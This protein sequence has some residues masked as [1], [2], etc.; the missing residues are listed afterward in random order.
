MRSRRTFLSVIA[1]MLGLVAASCGG[2]TAGPATDDGVAGALLVPAEYATIQL[3]VDAAQPGDLVLIDPGVYRES[4]VVETNRIV[5]RGIDRNSVILDGEFDESAEN[6]VIIFSDGV[7]IENLTVR[8]YT[9]NGLFW[10]GSYAD[11]IFVEGYR[12]SFV[13]VHNVGVYGIY[14]FNAVG[15]MFD[16]S[17]ASGSD[18]SS[19][20]VGQCDPCNALLYDVVGEYSGIGYSGTNSTGVVVA[21]SEFA[22]NAIGIM[23]NSSDFEEL[24]PNRGTTIIGNYI[25]DNNE[26]VVSLEEQDRVGL[27]SG[28]VLA[29]TT[30]NVVERNTIV[31][32][33]GAG[34]LVVDWVRQFGGRTGF[35]ASGNIVRDNLVRDNGFERARTGA[36]LVLVLE[37]P[38][39]GGGGNCFEG[40]TFLTSMPADIEDTVPCGAANSLPIELAPL[41]QIF[42]PA[43]LLWELVDYRN[44]PVPAYTFDTMPDA[45]T[46]SPVPAANMP[47]AID[48]DAI[49]APAVP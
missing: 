38:S 37:D 33:H 7:A 35:R 13:T 11:D 48:L 43:T 3:A 36:D 8:N 44:A 24:A 23:S 39:S 14:A 32:N 2:D 40:N 25:H 30:G 17:Y 1:A 41:D 9:K 18:E 45:A 21:N 16:H 34:V 6:G 29:G 15:G 20:Y 26:Y 22:N 31:G 47:M 12:A 10:T 42:G 46:A 49:T 5:I 19:F 27:S 28:V 4:I